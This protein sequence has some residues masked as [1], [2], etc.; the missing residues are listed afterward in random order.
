M[1]GGGV[2]QVKQVPVLVELSAATGT[3]FLTVPDE[4]D[5]VLH[6]FGEDFFLGHAVQDEHALLASDVAL[7]VVRAASYHTVPAFNSL[8]DAVLDGSDID[9]VAVASGDAHQRLGA[10]H[11]IKAS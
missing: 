1:L 9:F 7:D 8:V 11:A 2:V 3:E 4:F 6:R 5:G 10:G